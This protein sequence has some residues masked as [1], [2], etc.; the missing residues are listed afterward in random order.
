MR[1]GLIRGS[2]VL[3]VV[4]AASVGK[5]A[6]PI[7][8]WSFN[9]NLND[10]VGSLDGTF[11]GGEPIYV[12]GKSGKGLE[13]DGIDDSVSIA[14]ANPS[15]Y[16]ISAWVKPARVEA[17]SIIAHTAGDPTNTWSHQIRI[18]AGGVFEHYLYDGAAKSVMGTTQIEADTWYH[19]AITAEHNSTMHLYVNGQEEGSPVAVG[20]LWGAGSVFLM[21]SNSGNAMGWFQGVIDDMRIYDVIV[22]QGE[23]MPALGTATSPGPDDTAV[24]VLRDSVLS[25]TPG[26]FA[27]SHHVYFD[28]SFEDV[29][30]GTVPT[31][32]GLD[33][34]SLE[35]ERLDFGQTY[36]WRVDEVNGTPDKTVFKG[37][38]WSFTAEPYAIVIP[39]DVNHVT[40]SSA[41][42][43]NTPGMIVN[44]SGLTG[45]THSTDSEDMWLSMPGDLSPWLMFEFAEIQKLDQMLIWNSNSS[46]EG[47]IGWGLKDVTIETSIDGVDWTGLS[48]ATQ[49]SKAPG[50]PTYS[51]P[52]AIDFGL[53]Q[54]RYVRIN[55]LS[56]WGGLLKQY[57]VSEVQFYGLPVRARTPVPASGSA[58]V[59]PN[60]VV[61]WRAGRE[62]GQHTLY[63]GTEAEAVAADLAPSVTSNTNSLNLASLDLQ[64][65]TTYYW[66][67]DEVNE[68]ET[69]SVW[70][71]PVWSFT[72]VPY[73]TIDDF[74]S[75]GN[76]SPNRPFQAWLDGYGY[77][78]DEFFPVAYGGNGTGAGVGHDIW[79]PGSPYF[80]GEIMESG[81]TLPGSG[82]SLPFYYSN[83]GG[84]ASE[85]E[86]KFAAAQDWTVNGIQTLVI[87]VFG[88][89]NNTG[90]LY[91]KINNTK[92]VAPS[93]MVDIQKAGWQLWPI[94]LSTVNETLGNVTS[95]TIGV[96]NT[97]ASGLLY[98][99][100]IGLYP[101]GI[102]YVTPTEPD[103]ANLLAHYTFDGHARDSSG[104]GF[105]GEEI[106]APTYADGVSGQGIQFN[107]IDDYVNVVIDVPENSCTVAFWFKTLDPDCG[108]YSVVQNLLGGGGND[109]NIYLT[110][111]NVN[112][113]I[114]DT[115]VLTGA[116]LNAA[117]GQWHH[118]VHTY[119]DAVGGQRLYVDGLLQAGGTK[120][121]SDFDWQERVHFGW[122][123]NVTNE[124][125]DGM[126]DEARI[127]DRTL[128]PAEVA[129]LYGRTDPMVKPF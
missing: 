39:V 56:N 107:G 74:E 72:T 116:G 48:D 71:G 117:D 21:G 30:A 110:D 16:T 43:A 87:P 60:S 46:S 62:A 3:F 69:L 105:D 111:G 118:V 80:D 6:E 47:F 29:N 83:T 27:A 113:R 11:N 2:F 14:Y 5:G 103:S 108:L 125:E 1:R 92:I 96:E 10:V 77:S 36:F 67:V 78:A 91:L 82:Q 59:L 68:A 53:V 98:I 57:G 63:V 45:S 101:G 20:T 89:A 79:G 124:F 35:L 58:D 15:A 84:T 37:D 102:D 115:E 18:A 51:E 76:L 95:L 99:D 121:Q 12:N 61:T 19:V 42:A 128:S 106:G 75:Y 38:V 94:D 127:Y 86:R 44:G 26:E 73:V 22:P 50:L 41:T 93:D 9:G 129:W 122:S 126:I 114:W 4:M 104:N 17:M 55:V 85:I 49:I 119:G 81:I 7:S 52:Q 34:N 90:Q 40:A 112:A 8:H 24:D 70:P 13:F 31:A 100:D 25:W 54:T 97:A 32:S 88:A 28:T 120:A 109:R 33:V 23:I 65:G 66:R 123:T 64:L